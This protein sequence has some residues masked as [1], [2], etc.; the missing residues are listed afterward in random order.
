MVRPR[1]LNLA[2]T[3]KVAARPAPSGTSAGQSPDTTKA[4]TGATDP[5]PAPTPDEHAAARRPSRDGAARDGDK[6]DIP[7]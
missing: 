4:A 6:D 3:P 2:P 1:R 5:G 7:F